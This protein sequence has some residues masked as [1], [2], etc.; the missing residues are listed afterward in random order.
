MSG[1]Y[2][3]GQELAYQQLTTLAQQLQVALKKAL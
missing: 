2:S 3:Q 1:Y